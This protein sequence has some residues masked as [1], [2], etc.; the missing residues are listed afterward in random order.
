MAMDST[1]CESET[2]P[3]ELRKLYQHLRVVDVCDALDG[4]GYFDIGLMSPDVRPLWPGMKFWGVALTMRCVPANRPMWRLNTTEAIVNAH[5]L[6][7]KEVAHI[8]TGEM[9]PTE[10]V[11]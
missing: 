10:P 6:R 3:F 7:V 1:R 5:G 8:T 2:N 9:V 4:I 11:T